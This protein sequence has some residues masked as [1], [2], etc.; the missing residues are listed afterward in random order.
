MN[1]DKNIDNLLKN[2][3]FQTIINFL[4]H[5]DKRTVSHFLFHFSDKQ[6]KEYH[7]KD[8][9]Q[10]SQK[11]TMKDIDEVNKTMFI[12]TRNLQ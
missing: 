11:E 3:K 9:Q 4:Q 7:S 5:Q 12:L 2:V 1:R 10:Y 6:I 8:L